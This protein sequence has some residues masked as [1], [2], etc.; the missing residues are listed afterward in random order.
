MDVKIILPKRASE[1]IEMDLVYLTEVL[2]TN[3][4]GESFDGFLGGQFGYG[5]DFENDVFFMAHCCQ[6]FCEEDK[7]GNPTCQACKR[8]CNFEHKPSGLKIC[9]YKWIGRSQE[10]KPNKPTQDKWN[11]IFKECIE[12]LKVV[13]SPN[14]DFSN[15]KEHNISLKESANTDS[16][17][18]SKD[19]TSLNN[20]IQSNFQTASSSEVQLNRK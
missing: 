5:T 10:Y 19:E 17:I 14:G 8:E 12:S 11:I 16:Q 2:V 13:T 6:G 1:S 20:N 18:S 7:D 15:E 4:L 9:W 3:K